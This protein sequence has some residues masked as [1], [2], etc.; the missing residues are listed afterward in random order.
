MKGEGKKVWGA[1]VSHSGAWVDTGSTDKD[2][3]RAQQDQM[4]RE[5]VEDELKVNEAK[6]PETPR[7]NQAGVMN[8]KCCLNISHR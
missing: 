8:V 1:Q 5:T 6:E 4:G 3:K 7:Q 2:K